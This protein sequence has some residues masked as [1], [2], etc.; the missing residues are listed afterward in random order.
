VAAAALEAVAS[1]A[2][3]PADAI[4]QASG[5]LSGL[6]QQTPQQTAA[7]L[8]SWRGQSKHA[9]TQLRAATSRSAYEASRALAEFSG[10]LELYAMARASNG[11]QYHTYTTQ[12]SRPLIVHLTQLY[13]ASH[14]D[15]LAG[16]VAVLNGLVDILFVPAGTTLRLPRL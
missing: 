1:S 9:Q 6:A 4:P 16:E 2:L 5:V 14:A 3:L 13:N 10:M 15:R 12:R 11:R 8:D 7:A